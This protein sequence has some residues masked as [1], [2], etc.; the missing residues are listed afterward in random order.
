MSP[1]KFLAD[2]E[3]KPMLVIV[4][5]CVL[6]TLLKL[7]M[8]T[9][10]VVFYD[11]GIYLGMSKYILSHGQTGYFESIRP[12]GLSLILAP[13]LYLSH[14][15]LIIVRIL[16]IILFIFCIFLTL[17]ITKKLFGK[18]AGIWAAI[19]FTFSPTVMI[20]SG[21]LLT[22]ILAYSI[23]IFSVYSLVAAIASSAFLR[24]V[25]SRPSGTRKVTLPF[26]PKTGFMEK[27]KNAVASPAPCNST[28]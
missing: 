18:T 5:I 17:Y 16:S 21:Y 20:F 23:M 27:S 12:P 15:Y 22:D 4:A 8:Y 2:F 11:E 6:F 19:F 3:N 25:M 14:N 13:F 9:N 7:L 28:S 26:G 1:N 24:S 10:G